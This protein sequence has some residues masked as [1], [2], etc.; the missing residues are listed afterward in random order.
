MGVA[1]IFST[2]SREGYGPSVKWFLPLGPYA[3]PGS[4]DCAGCKG[5]RTGHSP[6]PYDPNGSK[7]IP[8][9]EGFKQQNIV[10]KLTK[11]GWKLIGAD[12]CGFTNK[13]VDVLGGAAAVEGFHIKHDSGNPLTK[14]VNGFPT[15]KQVDA[16]GKTLK[17]ESGF[18]TVDQLQQMIM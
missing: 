5:C 11:G 9:S 10:E 6:L 14:G 3:L 17:M 4:N 2:G 13:Q 12:W 1:L 16:D 8:N 7:P 18:K 15:W